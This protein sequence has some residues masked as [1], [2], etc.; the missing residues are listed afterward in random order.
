MVC[1]KRF[2]NLLLLM[3]FDKESNIDLFVSIVLKHMG[4]E[5]PLAIPRKQ[6]QLEILFG[7]SDQQRSH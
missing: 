4:L 7:H 3:K 5:Q 6:K 2:D 1:N